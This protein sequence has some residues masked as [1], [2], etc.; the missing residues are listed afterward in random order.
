M[1]EKTYTLSE[2]KRSEIEK[3]LTD[4]ADLKRKV[5]SI[6]GLG[7]SNTPWGISSL[8][9][10]VATRGDSSESAPAEQRYARVTASAQV[11]SNLQWTYTITEVEKSGAGYGNWTDKSGGLSGATAYNLNE[12]QNGTAAAG[13]VYGNGV[14]FNNLL[15]TFT[16]K[17][18]PNGTRVKIWP[19]VRTDNGATEWWFELPSGIDGACT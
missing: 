9:K 4:F 14:A 6:K 16:V 7:T 19:V 2:S 1:A 10:S 11:G 12:D 3:M 17:P 5:D 15:G 18:F 8:R 13:H